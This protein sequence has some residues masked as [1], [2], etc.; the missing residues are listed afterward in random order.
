MA[1]KKKEAAAEAKGKASKAKKA[2]LKGS[3]SHSHKKKKIHVSPTFLPPKTLE[4]RRQPEY[5]LKSTPGRNKLDHY[6]VIKLPLTT[7]AALKKTEESNTLVFLVDVKANKHHVK[8]AVKK[9]YDVDVA[10]VSTV[11]RPDGEKKAYV[12]LAPDNDALDISIKIGII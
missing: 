12:R 10:Q 11:I 3:R 4:L 2:A 9:L 8:Q 7:E 1:L 5:P 6:A